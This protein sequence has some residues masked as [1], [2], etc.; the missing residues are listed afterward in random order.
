M[1]ESIMNVKLGK[2]R[3]EAARGKG[4]AVS[5]KL[6]AEKVNCSLSLAAYSL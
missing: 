1:R 3:K 6:Q 2:K 4:Q 5:R